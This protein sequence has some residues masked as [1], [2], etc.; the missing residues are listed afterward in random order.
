MMTLVSLLAACSSMPGGR[1]APSHGEQVMAPVEQRGIVTDRSVES[2]APSVVTAAELWR[3][4]QSVAVHQVGNLAQATVAKWP[5]PSYAA[6]LA[7][8]LEILQVKY[9]LEYQTVINSTYRS[10]C[11]SEVEGRL[12]SQ[13]TKTKP[14][15]KTPRPAAKSKKD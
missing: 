13:A 1:S 14:V 12:S 7:T 2:P 9:Y 4:N 10:R 15:L 3:E 6:C 8:P 5:K 11:L